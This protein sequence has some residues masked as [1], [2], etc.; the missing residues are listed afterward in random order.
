MSTPISQETTLP[1]IKKNL[2]IYKVACTIADKKKPSNELQEDDIDADTFQQIMLYCMGPL[3]QQLNKAFD[4]DPET[5]ATESIPLVRTHTSWSSYKKVIKHYVFSTV[6]FLEQLEGLGNDM[7]SFILSKWYNFVPFVVS[8]DFSLQKKLIKILLDFLFCNHEQSQQHAFLLLHRIGRMNKAALEPILKSSFASI[9][10]IFTSPNVN[11]FLLNS[12]ILL[13]SIDPKESYR[14]LFIIL[15]DLSKT[16]KDSISNTD[17][18]K[19]A[20]AILYSWKHINRHRTIASILIETEFTSLKPLLYPFIEMATGAASFASGSQQWPIRLLYSSMVIDVAEKYHLTTQ[21]ARLLIEILENADFYLPP[22]SHELPKNFSII[23]TTHLSRKD[24]H[25]SSILLAVLD[26]VVSQLQHLLATQSTSPAFPETALP[27]VMRLKK[28]L[29]QHRKASDPK[30]FRF[31]GSVRRSIQSLMAVIVLNGRFI[32]K[33]RFAESVDVVDETA[34]E[35]FTKK[36][37]DKSLPIHQQPPLL[38]LW[39]QKKEEIARQSEKQS[40][41][42]KKREQALVFL[43]KDEDETQKKDTRREKKEKGTLTVQMN[44]RKTS[45]TKK[46]EETVLDEDDSDSDDMAVQPLD[47]PLLDEDLLMKSDSE[48]E[49]EERE[50]EDDDEES[51]APITKQKRT[52]SSKTA[53]P[54]KG[55]DKKSKQ[56][57]GKHPKGKGGK[58]KSQKERKSFQKRR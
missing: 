3:L 14:A 38:R 42:E 57:G 23:H 54:Q 7:T 33:R 4:I 36:Y 32:T 29:K 35:A 24:T 45:S 30:S 56:K 8:L 5:Q 11:R 2:A 44:Q 55:K 31:E 13:Y 16:L 48:S 53:R 50:D 18:S 51:E 1:A 26:E 19:D 22:T 40:E 15:R 41:L 10:N 52:H 43:Q 25:N 9:T 21:I 27:I 20:I 47:L 17:K 39:Q 49:P 34:Y 58:N 6:H 28:I 12:L 46:E 37:S